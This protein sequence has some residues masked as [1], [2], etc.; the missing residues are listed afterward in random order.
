MND[1]YNAPNLLARHTL[2]RSSQVNAQLTAIKAAFDLLPSVNDLNRG[3][4]TYAADSGTSNTY[5]VSMPT[6][7][8]EYAT[9]MEFRVFIGNTNTGPSTLNVDGLGAR[10]IK[11]ID[12]SDVEATDLSAGDV[13]DFVYN[14]TDM[15]MLSVPRTYIAGT[16]NNLNGNPNFSGNPMFSG[17]PDFSQAQNKSA[18]RSALGLAIGSAIQAHSSVLDG[19]T[20]SFT[21]A[22]LNALNNHLSSSSNP[23]GVTA[24]QVGALPSGGTAANSNQLGGLAAS[25]FARAGSRTDDWVWFRRS[26][27]GPALMAT[28]QNAGRIAEFRSGTGDGTIVATI[29]EDGSLRQHAGV[30][31]IL[32][33]NDNAVLMEQ[34]SA[35]GGILIGHDDAFII[36]AGE[37]AQM[38]KDNVNVD[39]E[40]GYLGADTELFVFTNLQN[41]WS[42]RRE[43]RFDNDGNFYIG[44]HRA[45]TTDDE[46]SGKGL[47]ADTL[48]G[49]HGSHFLNLG[50]ATGTLTGDHVQTAATGNHGTVRLSTSGENSTGTATGRVP[51]V[52][53][54]RQMIDEH[55]NT[56]LEFI[57]SV[58]ASGNAVIDFTEFDASKYDAYQFVL[59]NIVP[60]TDSVQLDVRTSSNGGTSYDNSSGNYR[61]ATHVVFDSNFDDGDGSTSSTLIRLTSG[62][63]VGS[64]SGEDG[65]SG[66]VSVFGPHLSRDTQ[67][68]S[69]L[70]L[71]THENRIVRVNGSGRR[72]SAADVDAL[73]FFF[74]SGNI[75]SGTITMYGMRNS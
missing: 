18:I 53:G 17:N 22:L 71:T 60:A 69:D 75:E 31:P 61:W 52:A 26:S 39:G 73:R 33:L 70:S 6:T 44:S 43:F 28:R 13:H 57:R 34:I 21:T 23:H 45:L 5:V 3:M 35:R 14:G 32:R 56:G 2:A 68:S 4:L 67:I 10:A 41:G 38:L 49:N 64:A 12:G 24:A 27:I 55:A 9:G 19:T 47:D 59:Q 48:D 50:N 8:V 62:S 63:T 65:V 37:A 40:S 30:G 25:A 51:N 54:V 1:Y 16:A 72:N 15:I 66:I 7:I 46:G 36:G 58:N 42:N 11:R 74:S 29:E 20:A